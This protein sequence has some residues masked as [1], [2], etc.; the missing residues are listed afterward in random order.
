ME[1]R[2]DKSFGVI[3]VFRDDMRNL[4]FCFVHHISGHWGFPKGHQDGNE[5]EQETALREL[6]EE[7]G[8]VL[9]DIDI[10][11]GKFFTEKYSFEREN[12]HYNK[13]VQYFLGAVGSMHART[14]A[15]FKGEIPEMRWTSYAEGRAL[16][17]FQET[18]NIYF[19]TILLTTSQYIPL[20][21]NIF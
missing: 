18:K 21:F 20:F 14:P 9:K 8:I 17:T 12:V 6:K 5:S 16:L 10:L 7:T 15:V 1:I 13:L 2:E 4:S 11:Q 3:P 19:Q